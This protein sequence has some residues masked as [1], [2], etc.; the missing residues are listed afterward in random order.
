MKCEIKGL[1]LAAAATLVALLLPA[2][3]SAAAQSGT[4]VAV[5]VGQGSY[6]LTQGELDGTAQSALIGTGLSIVNL[7]SNLDKKGTGFGVAFGYRFSPYLAAE[8]AYLDLGKAK[9]NASGTVTDGINS[10]PMDIA[11]S[12][13]SS[14]PALS[15]LGSVPVGT[16]FSLDARAGA[17]FSKTKLSLT[18][19]AQ[20]V[21]DTESDSDKHTGLLY[22]IGGTWSFTPVAAVRVGYT[23]YK[24]AV[25]GDR[26]VKQF[27]AG[28][29]YSFTH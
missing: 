24:E 25:Y 28:F 8:A 12:F 26:D 18:A 4:Y 7:S 9:W 16:Q 6:D 5:D 29:L 22:G 3:V 11:L 15:L 2:G 27:S 23:V 20:G 21:S 14:G 19:S 1:R 10:S 17:F 13:K